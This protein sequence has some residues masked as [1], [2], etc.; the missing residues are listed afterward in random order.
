[1]AFKAINDTTGPNGLVPTL[2]VFG[3]YPRMVKL[4]APLPSVIQQANAIKKAIVEIQKLQAE[5]QIIDALN[6]RN[7]P[8]TDTVYNLPPN[9][10]VLV[11]REGN[12][13]QA[14]Y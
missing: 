10:P 7:G 9:S 4:D 12:M 3:V 2:L 8:K 5:R 11:Q 14:K 6:M 13:G 1:M